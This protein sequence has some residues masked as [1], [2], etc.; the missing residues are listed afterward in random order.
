M[1]PL[2][3]GASRT[4]AT[5]S[6][7]DKVV[8]D[9]GGTGVA[10]SAAQ[11]I[12][13]VAFDGRA[14]DIFSGPD[15]IADFSWSDGGD[16]LAVA[17][18]RRGPNIT[19]VERATGRSVELPRGDA[20]AQFVLVR[21]IGGAPLPADPLPAAEPPPSPSAG[22]SGADVAGFA[23]VLS[24]WV[25]RDG[26]TQVAHLERLVPTEAGG[27]RVAAALQVLPRPGS[28][29]ILIWIWASDGA[30]GWL[31]DGANGLHPL[32][33]PAD[34]PKTAFDL[35]WRP[36]GRALAATAGR[37][38]RNGF[39][40]VF[41][42]AAPGGRRTT[43]VPIVG[44][45]D[46]LEGWW[47]PTELRVGHG[48]CTDGCAGR[49]AYDA[50]LRIRDHHLAQLT[51][52][53]RRH[54]PIDEILVM[55]PG[56]VLSMINEATADDITIDWP[57]GPGSVE[58]IGFGGDGHS[59]LLAVENAAGTDVERIADPIGRAVGGRLTDPQ[60][61]LLAHLAGRSLR[62]DVSPDGAWATVVDR[63]DDIHLVRLA[64]GRSWPIDRDRILVW[65]AVR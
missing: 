14:S 21:L 25:D 18:D 53:D 20:V 5:L 4:L 12:R 61:T 10:V 23:G 42:I 29:D 13:F 55:P 11:T 60:P 62:I 46:R 64:D 6:S 44:A 37:A 27:L 16:Y 59:L 33:L 38:T 28:S 30:L 22:P 63:V 15:P 40:D 52:A 45:Y 32:A 7:V 50:R 41:V 43:I 65:P 35:S 48:V 8:I 58:P 56:I 9:P 1:W 34:W 54:E 51:P 57:D 19:I 2:R 49:Y 31:W 24:A 47:S 36:D 39:E 26:P 17:T 3:G